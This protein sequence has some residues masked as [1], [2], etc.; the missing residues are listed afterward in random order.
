MRL[1]APAVALQGVQRAQQGG[2]QLRARPFAL[3]PQQDG[4]E[5]GEVLAGVLEID[6]DEL[7]GDLEVHHET[8][9]AEPGL[10]G[11]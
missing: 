4:V 10:T 6:P 9:R 1:V 5:G 7:G 2:G 8:P 11:P 3:Q